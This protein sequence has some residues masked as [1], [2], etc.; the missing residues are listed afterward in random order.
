MHRS[1]RN[2]ISHLVRTNR[3]ASPAPSVVSDMNQTGD[4]SVALGFGC[5]IKP[6]EWLKMRKTTVN[7]L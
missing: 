4:A 1:L 3:S 7:A 5:G 6:G 2:S